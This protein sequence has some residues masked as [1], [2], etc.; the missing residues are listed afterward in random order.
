MKER[1]INDEQKG[2][3]FL[4]LIFLIMAVVVVVVVIS[5]RSDVVAEKISDDKVIRLLF[6]VDNGSDNERQALFSNV[7]IYYPVSKKAASV[8]IPGNTGAIY[9]S[10][11]RTDRIDD[12]YK[13][14]GIDVY[15]KEVANLLGTSIPFSLVIHFEDFMRVVDMLGGLRVFVPFPID[16]EAENGER[17]LLPSGVVTL[18]GDKISV[19]LQYRLEDED[20]EDVQERYQNVVTSFFTSLHEKKSSVFGKTSFFNEYKQFFDV[21]LKKSQDVMQLLSLIADMDSE[22]IAC[23]T[24]TGR[25]R[26]VDNQT[27]LF[28]L[29]NGEFIKEAVRQSTSILISNSGTLAS[30]IYVLDIK[31]GTTVQGLAHNTAILFQNASYDVLNATNADSND[32]EKTVIID[33]IGNKEMADM[34]GRFIHCTNIV[35]EEVNLNATETNAASVDF[36]IILGRDFDGRYVRPSRN[37]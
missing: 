17:W 21:N 22:S 14:M 9:Q 28:P 23:Q 16:I 32:Y 11:K 1:K 7:L 13:D 4:A 5:M 29:N 10:L 25:M 6:V 35:E 36:T 26:I 12:V 2:F 34:V 19:Y 24:V 3:L 31:N 18:D 30:R 37:N 27:L 15:R 33:H 8:N 20:E